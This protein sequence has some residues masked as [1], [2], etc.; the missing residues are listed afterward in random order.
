MVEI[1]VCPSPFLLDCYLKSQEPCCVLIVDIFRASTSICSAMQNG[2]EKI[3]TVADL[4]EAKEMKNKG[5]TVVA[6]RNAK[7]C[8]FADFG[9]SPLEFQN[10]K[11]VSEQLVFTTTNCTV[12]IE[13]AKEYT[14][15]ILIGAFS[16][17]SS[18]VQYCLEKQTKIVI[19]CA[20]WTGRICVEDMIFAG[21]FTERFMQKNEIEKMSDSTQIALD[22]W[23]ENKNNLQ[24][25]LATTEHYK[26]L[27]KND[28][29]KDINYCLRFD[30]NH[31]IPKY[32]AKNGCFIKQ[33]N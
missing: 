20:G 12:A 17:I 8:D 9:N 2:A 1:E 28:L 29:L 26:R 23:K 25:Y 4:Q 11:K 15:N 6:E 21:A 30:T 5:Y 27:E 22:I 13:K 14:N 24:N 7:R 3:V 33:N 18:I 16:N 31:I 10:I 19:L 32:D